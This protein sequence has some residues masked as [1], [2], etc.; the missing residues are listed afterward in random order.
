[1]GEGWSAF[2]ISRRREIVIE[3]IETKEIPAAEYDGNRHD[4]YDNHVEKKELEKEDKKQGKTVCFEISPRNFK[5]LK[6]IARKTDVRLRITEKHGFPF[7]LI[8][9]AAEVSG[10]EVWQPFFC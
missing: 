10:P 9:A 6:P 1:M 3:K 8:L 4:R 5:R 2:L 7:W